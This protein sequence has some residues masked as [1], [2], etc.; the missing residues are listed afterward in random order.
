MLCSA[1]PGPTPSSPWSSPRSRSRKAGRPGAA[2]T[3]ADQDP[4]RPDR[5]GLLGGGFARDEPFDQAELEAL[6]LLDGQATGL[7][8]VEGPAQEVF[9]GQPNGDQLQ[10]PLQAAGDA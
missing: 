5:F 1:G 4:F 7:D 6:A 3:A 8:L 2:S 10:Q 9:A